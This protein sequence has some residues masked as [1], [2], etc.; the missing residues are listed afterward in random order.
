MKNYHFGVSG[1][2]IWSIHILLG[3]YFIYLG[4]NSISNIPI[5][6]NSGIILVVLGSVMALYQA[7]IWYINY[8]K[9]EH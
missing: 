4:Y 8:N 3:L 7:H 9:H 2:F 1:E 6:K 5:G